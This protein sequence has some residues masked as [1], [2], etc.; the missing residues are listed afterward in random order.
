MLISDMEVFYIGAFLVVMLLSSDEYKN[1]VLKNAVA[2]G[3]NRVHMFIGKCIVYGITAMV[4]AALILAAFISTALILAAFISTAYLLLETD[5]S[6]PLESTLPLKVL[7]LG[8]AANVPFSLATVVLT[9]ALY[10]IFQKDA[11]VGIGCAV[12]MY[13]IP[14]AF[15]LLGFQI[16]ICARIAAWMPWNFV[17]TEVSAAFSIIQMDALWMH[18]EGFLKEMIAG[19]VGIVLFGALG[20]WGFRKKDIA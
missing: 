11:Q 15:R 2:G 8:A 18:P 7:L 16:P 5:F 17:K 4:S 1:G 13:L 20:I 12:I 3:I 19:A 9:M 10:N 14:T 6:I